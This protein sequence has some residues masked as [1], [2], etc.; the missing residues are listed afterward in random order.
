MSLAGNA[1]PSEPASRNCGPPVA[2]MSRP[3]RPGVQ[4]SCEF[5]DT[6]RLDPDPSSCDDR[7]AREGVASVDPFPL[8]DGSRPGD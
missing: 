7:R 2:G 6:G 5:R 1:T 3:S 4:P 8:R